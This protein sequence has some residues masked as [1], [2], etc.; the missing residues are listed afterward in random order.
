[1]AQAPYTWR[2]LNENGSAFAP[3]ASRD[4]PSSYAFDHKR[5]VVVGFGE[6]VQMFGGIPKRTLETHERHGTRWIRRRPAMQPKLGAALTYDDSIQSVRAWD[7]TSLWHWNGTNWIATPSTNPS[8]TVGSIT[9]DFAHRQLIHVRSDSIATETLIWNGSG[10]TLADSQAPWAPGLVVGAS[11]IGAVAL[12]GY[13]SAR[14]RIWNGTKWI[15]TGAAPQGR[16][17]AIATQSIPVIVTRVGQSS[18]VQL[19]TFDPFVGMALPL[20]GSTLAID[21]TYW[22]TPVTASATFTDNTLILATDRID[23]HDGVQWARRFDTRGRIAHDPIRDLTV[24]VGYSAFNFAYT[25]LFERRSFRDL[26]IQTPGA[27]ALLWCS[28]Q[29]GIFSFDQDGASRFDES[30]WIHT[31][32]PTKL[33]SVVRASTY[34]DSTGTA[35]FIVDGGETWEWNPAGG[36]RRI[37]TA[38]PTG[39]H[40]LGYDRDRKVRVLFETTDSSPQTPSIKEWK[41]GRWTIVATPTSALYHGVLS[42]V[43]ELGGVAVY[44]GTARQTAFTTGEIHVWD[45][46]LLRTVNGVQ[47]P[48]AKDYQPS[49]QYYD[50]TRKRYVALSAHEDYEFGTFALSPHVAGVQPGGSWQLQHEDP[51]TAGLG[52]V[53]CFSDRL[54]P[55]VPFRLNRYGEFDVLPIGAG[56]VLDMS[57]ALG[58]VGTLDASGRATLRLTIPA[59]STLVGLELY[60]AAVYFGSAGLTG[61][62][63]EATLRIFP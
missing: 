32:S 60:G 14:P 22:Q 48:D 52:Y 6:F 63:A 1:M 2:H 49:L 31:P 19:E 46:T 13:K 38:L 47:A 9:Y 50:G 25:S 29:R 26:T 58:L 39:V 40:S 27:Q 42:H 37:A 56:P 11:A 21:D 8:K 61:S 30:G 36:Y 5:G 12:D 55:V 10:W 15:E 24:R 16:V 45:G 41:N 57:F 20:P 3:P 4:F 7:G 33:P 54:R 17:L 53:F 28:T 18:M 51:S 62:S 34:D 23:E 43:P 44:G 35:V 59:Q